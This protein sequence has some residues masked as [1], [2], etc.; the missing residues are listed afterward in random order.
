MTHYYYQNIDQ[1][2]LACGLVYSVFLTDR[3]CPRDVWVSLW[4][5]WFLPESL[6]TPM[7]HSS[8][9]A[10][11]DCVETFVGSYQDHCRYTHW[12]LQSLDTHT[13]NF[14][15]SLK[16]DVCNKSV[17]VQHAVRHVFISFWFN[18]LTEPC[19]P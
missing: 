5:G 1:G 2:Y 7:S 15:G 11:S 3:R 13:Q 12:S 17:T 4:L 18:P 8:S 9:P 19:L 16:I 14:F 6:Q 10:S